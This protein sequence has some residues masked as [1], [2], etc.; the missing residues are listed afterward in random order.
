MSILTT[1][2]NHNFLTYSDLLSL[3]PRLLSL[4][5]R[6]EMI[7]DKRV[8]PPFRF[9]SAQGNLCQFISKH[10]TQFFSRIMFPR[11]LRRDVFAENEKVYKLL[12]LST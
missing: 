10:G 6:R 9:Y 3:Q 7:K 11:A 8:T 5:Y 1:Q 12:G 2:Q 4:L